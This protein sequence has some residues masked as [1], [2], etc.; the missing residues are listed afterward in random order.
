VPRKA[1]SAA[2]IGHEIE[3]LRREIDYHNY[4]YYVLDNPVISD[5]EY[6][7]LFRRLVELEDT[8]PELRSPASPTQRVGAPPAERFETVRHTLPMLSLNNAMAENELREFDRRVQRALERERPVEYVAEPKL[9]GTA[10]ELVYENGELTVASTRGDG[11]NGENVTANVKTIRSVPLRL[12]RSDKK[13]PPVPARLEVRG[14]VILPKAA[15]RQL[16]E[17]RNKRG[18]PLFANPRNA[19]AGSLRQLDSRITAQRPLDIFCH[20][21]GQIAGAVELKSH[22]EFLQVISAWGLKTNPLNQLCADADAVV[23]YHRDMAAQRAALPYE[24]DGIVAKVNSLELQRQ[25]GEISRSPRWAIAYKFKAQQGTTKIIGIIPSVGRT[26]VITPTAQLEPVQVG[27]VTISSASLHNM[28]EIERKDIRIGDTVLIERAGDV[29]PYIVKVV[30]KKRTGDEAKFDMPKECPACQ[31]EVVREEGATAYR[32]IGMSCPAKLRESIRHFAS[33]HAL[34]I[35]GIGDKLVEQLTA[36]DL[37]KNVADLYELAKK[38]KDLVDLDHM[39]EKS[40]QNILDNI[41]KSRKTTLAR[42]IYALGIPQVGEHMAEVL[43]D[44]FPSI[45]KLKKASGKKLLGVREVGPETAR[46]IRAFF[47][48]EQNARIIERL[49]KAGVNP[50]A[51]RR[52]RTGKLAGKTFVL[53]GALSVPRDQVAREIEACGGRVSGSVSKNTDYVVAGEDP[54]S[55]LDKARELAVKTITE[56]QLRKLLGE[57]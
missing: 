14:E 9:D 45:A 40:A 55:K 5:A 57:T 11:S 50:T 25:L 35:D 4:R 1:S 36:K 38:K 53:T 19:A 34:N 46:E 28:D 10:I 15:F 37:V 39:G 17:E 16:N 20:G 26:G 51:E 31:S 48:L 30:L 6:D 7:A 49:Q 29:I 43:A 23:Q 54:G 56:E 18:E 32:C 41:E 21:F 42:F 44:E 13:A 33:K 22:W 12:I 47:K 27:G 2:D 24:V 8:H 52:Q 3:Q